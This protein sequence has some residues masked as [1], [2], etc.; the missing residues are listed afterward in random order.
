MRK[1]YALLCCAVLS[2]SGAFAQSFTNSG[3]LLPSNHRSGGVTGVA[4]VNHDGLDD[5]I[6]MD[7]ST[8]LYVLYQQ[9]NGSFTESFYGTVSNN[10]Q[11]GMAVGDM[12]NDN[13]LDVITGGYYDGVHFVNINSATQSTTQAF[14]AAS[15]F[16]QACNFADI[17]NDGWADAFACHDDGESFIFRNQNGTMTDGNDMIDLTIYPNSD[18]SGNYGTTWTDF[19]RDGD[20]DLFIAKCRQAVNDPFDPR[21]TNVLLVNDGNNNYSDEAHERGLVN[22]QQSWTSDFADVDN[23]GD[24]D[25]FITTHSGTME[26]YENDGFGYFTNVTAGSGLELPGF[27]LQGK[28]EDMDNDG[29]VDLLYA[30]GVSGY[31]RNNGDLTFAAQPLP[32]PGSATVHSFGIG[33]LDNDGWLDVYTTYGTNYVTPSNTPDRLYLNNGGTNHW[34]S[35]DLTGTVS[36]KRAIGALV[37]IHGAWGVQIREVRAGESYGISNSFKMHFGL[38]A[39]QTIDYAVIYWPAGG[40]QVIDNPGIDQVHNVTEST[41]TPPTASISANSSTTV[42]PG[43]S[44][45]LSATTTATNFHWNTGATGSSISVTNQG[46]YSVIAY[47]AN[48]CAS[49]SNVV[50]VDVQEEPTPSITAAGDLEFCAGFSVELTASAGNGYLWSTGEITQTITVSEAGEY[51]VQVEGACLSLPSEPIAVEVFN[52]PVTPTVPSVEVNS[53]NTATLT[54]EGSDVRWYDAADATTP[55]ATGNEFVTPIIT[56]TTTFW[57]ESVSTYGGDAANGGLNSN[58]ANGGFF[59]ANTRYMIFDAF[60]DMIIDSVKVYAQ[61]AGARTFEVRD[62]LG[63]SVVSGT[64]TLAA[65]EQYVTLNFA[66]PMGSSYGIYCNDAAPGLWRDD[67]S[68]NGDLAY[69]FA[70]GTLGAITNSSV[71]GDM[72]NNY[73]YFFY[74]WHVSTPTFECVSDREEVTITIVGV[75]ELSAVNSLQMF[76]NP[77]HDEV[78]INVQA[79][80]NDKATFRLLDQTGRVVTSHQQMIYNGTQNVRM[81]LE[82]VAAGIYTVQCLSNGKSFSSKLVVE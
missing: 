55:I 48:G 69:P 46:N 52:T 32:F 47:D 36:N 35:F 38:G 8:D 49:Q 58:T 12:D 17:N 20:I 4:D 79:S 34:V 70:L 28:L 50:S 21:R 10:E 45:T 63:N 56:G 42:C 25:A 68:Q 14:S 78:M 71:S 23:D 22:L 31:M 6:V 74:D 37:E 80:V 15:I 67:S 2:T 7:Q 11:W 27:Y 77:A 3:S 60:A 9:A 19:D 43:Q 41:C 59:N 26:L 33:D 13:Y 72:S 66:V 61:T 30:G 54:A 57:V 53:G 40:I 75:E 24:F 73:Y 81:S 29:F 64:F 18:N 1:F 5:I 65:G 51:S 76:P 44:V 39:S 16:M 82:N 62:A